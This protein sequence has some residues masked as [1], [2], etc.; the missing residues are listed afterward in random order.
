MSAGIPEV[1][2]AAAVAAEKV[3]RW[4]ADQVVIVG[5]MLSMILTSSI[6]VWDKYESRNDRRDERAVNE[7]TINTV[8]RSADEREESGRKFFSLL[9]EKRS[10][11]FD[12]RHKMLLDHC[13]MEGEKNREQQKETNKV[14]SAL[15]AEI[16]K[17]DKKG[18]NS[19]DQE[20]PPL[21]FL[22]PRPLPMAPMPRPA[23]RN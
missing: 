1:A 17:R 18:G 10:R 9:D 13:T 22:L 11:E 20:E 3:S 4:K 14:V 8:N 5:C 19:D 23:Y 15:A 16:A 12:S 7:R 21:V 6:I 2:A